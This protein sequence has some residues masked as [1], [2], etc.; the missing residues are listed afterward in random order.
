MNVLVIGNG[1]HTNKRIIPALLK[2][3]SIKK[4]TV[5]S[6]NIQKNQ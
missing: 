1:L 6:R 2:I 4:I 5:A 3:L